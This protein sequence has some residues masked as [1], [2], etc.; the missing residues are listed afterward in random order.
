MNKDTEDALEHM[1][2][3]LRSIHN[4]VDAI[5]AQ[6]KLSD[7]EVDSLEQINKNIKESISEIERLILG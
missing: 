1:V 5:G 2:I 3:H 6:Y 4:E 7:I